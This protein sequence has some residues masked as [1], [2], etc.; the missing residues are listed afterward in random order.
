MLDMRPEAKVVLETSGF[1][2]AARNAMCD[3]YSQLD[4]R[5][6]RAH[7]APSEDVDPHT[8]QPRPVSEQLERDVAGYAL[9][10]RAVD[11]A[12]TGQEGLKQLLR[13][14]YPLHQQ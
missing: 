9:E 13:A 6:P 14:V 8:Q 1:S 11:A 10:C 2:A 5:H 4:I 12:T 7:W 3:H